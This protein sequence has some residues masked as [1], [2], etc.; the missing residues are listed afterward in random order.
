MPKLT[1]D[2][3]E[4]EFKEGQTLIQ[5][6]RDNGVDIPH[7]CWHPALS[8]SGNCRMCLVE[9]EQIPKLV[10]SCATLAT[11][12]MTVHTNSEKTV[13]ARKAVLEFI[14]INH[15][16][17]CPICDEA[18]ECKLQDYAYAYSVGESRMTE[19]KN[20]KPKRVELG[21]HVV[22]DAERCIACSRC[23]RFADEIAKSPL[24]T[25]VK[26][27]DR[28]FV[29]TFPGESF[30]NPYSMNTVDI[31]PVGALTSKDFRFKSRVWEMSST[32][33]ICTGCARGC[34]INIWVRDNKI[35]RIT[36]R[37]NLDVNK[38][39]MCDNGRLNYYKFVNAENRVDGPF[40]RED[41]ELTSVEW[42]DAFSF[43]AENLK[44]FKPHEIAFIGSAF[45]TVED[46]YALVKLAEHLNVKNL[47]YFRYVVPG[48][49]DDI[50]I[51][52]DKSPNAL[53]A[54]LVGVK[55]KSGGKNLDEIFEDVKAGKIKAVYVLEQAPDFESY[56][57]DALA[58]A[59]F[60]VVHA[61]NFGR[62]TEL[63]NAVFPAATYAEKHG[64]FVNFQ[65]RIQRLK[66]AVATAEL[67]RSLD[68]MPQSHWDKL[69]TK[70][71]RW[72]QGKKYDAL[73]SWKIIVRLMQKFGDKINFDMA[74][75]IFKDLATHNSYFK[76]LDYDVIGDGGASLE[77]VNV[78]EE[79]L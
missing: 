56:M 11:E 10:I 25:F 51:R 39:W 41:S 59:E 26:R 67:D 12:G 37:E 29:S 47:D 76:N 71:D 27:G 4:V 79:A 74:E 50:L 38:Y 22:Y 65:G 42:T 32:P 78:S 18:G 36:P 55:P 21:P 66:P 72:A 30:D 53:G 6:A 57:L 75:E 9:V 54:E 58:K 43:V 34:N 13:D 8:V 77:N 28:V 1:L 35:Q 70:F 45:A 3:K 60:V 19:L 69:G 31:C 15:P 14:L 24:L 5:V 62:L 49:G 20:H 64:T 68:G 52:E 16:L 7:F 33:S 44:K 63:A 17:D 23:I 46:N 61:S 73:P 40:L 48:S 2:G